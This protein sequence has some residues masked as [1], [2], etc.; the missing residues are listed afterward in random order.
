MDKN[1]A[2]R[3]SL[4]H[5]KGPSRARP[6]P[7]QLPSEGEIVR[8]PGSDDVL[9]LPSDSGK[10]RLLPLEQSESHDCHMMLIFFTKRKFSSIVLLPQPW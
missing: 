3:S 2:G 1:D 8:A 4:P 6:M 9:K 10:R 5:V 7:L